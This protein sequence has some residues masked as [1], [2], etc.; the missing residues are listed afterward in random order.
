VASACRLLT[1]TLLLMTLIMSSSLGIGRQ[2][3]C[4]SLSE[5]LFAFVWRGEVGRERRV[6]RKRM[7]VSTWKDPLPMLDEWMVALHIRT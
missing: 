3:T 6:G 5:D 7:K 2:L 4:C 1:G